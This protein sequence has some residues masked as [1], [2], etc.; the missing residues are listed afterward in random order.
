MKKMMPEV[1]NSRARKILCLL[2][3]LLWQNSAGYQGYAC[4]MPMVT[5]EP[6]PVPKEILLGDFDPATHPDFAQITEYNA[7]QVMYLQ[8][9]AKLALDSLV[10]LAEQSGIRLNVISA[11]RSFQTQKRI[12]E[13]KIAM[14]SSGSFATLPRNRQAGIIREILDY[15]AM[16]GTSRHHWGTDV[17]FLS[18]EL[19]FWRGNTGKKT[20]AWL[21]DNAP[22]FGFEL[23]YSR[24][25]EGGHNYEP[26][27]WSYVPLSHK[28]LEDYVATISYDDIQGFSGAD[29]AEE[30]EIIP[31]YLQNI[32]AY[33]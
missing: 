12:W 13:N 28:M 20:F 14:K 5:S 32:F 16:P 15:S 30:M 29:L 24:G 6:E 11:T 4:I 19:A 31:R 7:H 2:L 17:D 23:V 27:H 21:S 1:Y 8:R 18:V 10:T 3:I 26:W 25:R 22:E 9:D 33:R